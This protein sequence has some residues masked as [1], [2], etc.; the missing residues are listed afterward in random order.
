MRSIQTLVISLVTV[1]F[2]QFDAYPQAGRATKPT[3]VE[4]SNTA[5]LAQLSTSLQDVARK[6]EP[7]VVQIFNSSYAV[8]R[9]GEMVILQQ[10]NSGSGILITSDGYI[11]T[12]A[13]LVEGSRRLQV[14]L[15]AA[16]SNIGGRMLRATLIGKD[17]QTDLAVIKIDLEGLPF[18]AFADS[19]SLSQ[20]QIVLAFGSPL[21][22]DN[23]VS[24]GVVSAVDRQLS[25]DDPSV[26]IQTD[27]AINPGNSGGPLV[28]TAGQ[29]VGMNTFILTKSGGSEGVGFAIP[30]NLVSAICRQIRVDHHVH[31]HQIGI[32]VRAITPAMAQA[33]NL[34]VEDGV[35]I[36]DVGPQSTA[37]AAGLRVGDIITKLHG[38]PIQNVRQLALNL[39]SYEVGEKAEMAILRGPETLS[40]SVPVVEREDDPQRF[41]DLVTEQDNAIAKL[42]I[43]GLTIDEKLS[44]QLPPLRTSGGVL[45][46]AK[47]AM[48][49]LS[50]FGDELVAGDVIHSLNGAEVEDVT[51]LR[52]TLSALND[53]APLVLQVERMGRLQFVVLENN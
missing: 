17:R 48:G 2:A 15:N 19:D 18:L 21:G 12:N 36:E 31:H 37:E 23:S 11:V 1:C 5:S 50:R 13:H 34:P 4:P 22:L 25:V 41:E 7:S 28:N 51:S 30:G 49:G 53:D 24:M 46:A 32:A 27:A 16:S 42:G 29:V 26:Y 45:V 6:V 44:A 40:F 35:V 20:G 38:H 3:L 9:G 39:Y 52:S 14:R 33:L 10:R 47:M 43:L 8:E